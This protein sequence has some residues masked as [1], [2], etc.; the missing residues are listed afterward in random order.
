MPFVV[1]AIRHRARTI[2][3]TFEDSAAAPSAELKIFI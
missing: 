2:T 1:E 3:I